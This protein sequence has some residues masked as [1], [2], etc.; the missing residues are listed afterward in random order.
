MGV[1]RRY[2]CVNTETHLESFYFFL[3]TSKRCAK[4]KKAD[5]SH[6]PPAY[7]K[8]LLLLNNFSDYYCNNLKTFCCTALA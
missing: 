8:S 3:L 4:N 1:H 2:V 6:L 5:E 7:K